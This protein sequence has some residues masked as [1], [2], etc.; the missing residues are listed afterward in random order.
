MKNHKDRQDSPRILVRMSQIKSE[1]GDVIEAIERPAELLVR[2]ARGAVCWWGGGQESGGAGGG[3]V[4]CGVAECDWWF[5]EGRE[6]VCLVGGGAEG[7][8]W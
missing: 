7:G 1:G 3:R 6:L 2:A 4:G 5:G 8:G